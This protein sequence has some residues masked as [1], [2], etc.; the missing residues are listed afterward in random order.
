MCMDSA[1]REQTAAST[2]TFR[3]VLVRGVDDP[4][5]DNCKVSGLPHECAD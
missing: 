5:F 4:R 3:R 1:L 2:M